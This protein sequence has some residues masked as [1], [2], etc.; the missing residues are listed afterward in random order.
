MF[1]T[2]ADKT[3][4]GEL[5]PTITKPFIEHGR[6]IRGI[7]VTGKDQELLQAISDPIFD[8]P[9]ISNK[10]IQQNIYLILLSGLEGELAAIPVL[11]QDRCDTKEDYLFNQAP[12]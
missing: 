3:P 9:F 2:V 5:L 11:L 8:V 1:A 12:S 10:G 6:R 7:E 4:I